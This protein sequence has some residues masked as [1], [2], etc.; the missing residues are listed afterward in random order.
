MREIA[1]R[2]VLAIVA[3]DAHVDTLAVLAR[4]DADD[5]T[6][7]LL[8]VLVVVPTPGF[9]DFS[10]VTDL[11]PLST[12]MSTVAEPLAPSLIVASSDGR[13]RRLGRG[14]GG[15]GGTWPAAPARGPRRSGRQAR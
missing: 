9:V 1:D 11:F 5:G 2:I 14:G 6:A 13:G 7:V 4:A 10:M 3:E 15:A 8:V 12:R